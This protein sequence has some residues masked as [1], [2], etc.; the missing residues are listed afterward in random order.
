M[1]VF[2]GRIIKDS[3]EAIN[4]VISEA[5]A[6]KMQSSIPDLFAPMIDVNKLNAEAEKSINATVHSSYRRHAEWNGIKWFVP[7]PT[8]GYDSRGVPH[9][10]IDITIYLVASGQVETDDRNYSLTLVGPIEKLESVVISLLLL[11]AILDD[12]LSR[13]TILARSGGNTVWEI[14]GHKPVELPD[15]LLN[16]ISNAL[17]RKSVAAWLIDFGTLGRSVAPLIVGTL[18]GM[19]F[20]GTTKALPVGQQHWDYEQLIEA[21]KAMA[22]TPTEAKEMVDKALPFLKTD[23]TLEEAVRFTLQNATSGG[24]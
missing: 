1:K 15:I 23:M 17:T 8:P 22:Y 10:T 18:L 6:E 7:V 11:Q 20:M 16:R 9:L 12:N 14:P 24:Q 4:L 13:F 2:P 21:L 3:K 19:Q 5:G